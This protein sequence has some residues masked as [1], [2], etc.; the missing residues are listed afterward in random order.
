MIGRVQ[1]WSRVAVHNRTSSHDN[2][3]WYTNSYHD[4]PPRRLRRGAAAPRGRTMTIHRVLLH[5]LVA[6]MLYGCAAATPVPTF[7]ARHPLPPRGE[8][9]LLAIVPLISRVPSGQV[10]GAI[11]AGPFCET[12]SKATWPVADGATIGDLQ[13]MDALDATLS[14]SGYK[15]VKRQ[16]GP[17]DEPEE[18]KAEL[19]I[20]GSLKRVNFN[21]C[22]K[23]D[24]S[25]GEAAVEIEWQIFDRQ[26]RSVLLAL[27]T[28]GSAKLPPQP[29]GAG[30]VYVSAINAAL[31]NLLAEERFVTTVS[32]PTQQATQE[33]TP[34]TVTVVSLDADLAASS[35]LIEY[36]RDGVV[37]IPVGSGHGS[38][39]VVSPTGLVIT[40]AH[41]IRDDQAA[42]VAELP[43]D[44]K[45]K[46]WLVRRNAEFDV[47]L[48]QLEPGEYRAIPVGSA[49]SLH[50]GD[51]VFA[52]GAPLDQRLTRT[53]TKGV[54]SA[55]REDPPRKWIQSDVTVHPG[56]SGG[57]LLDDRGRVVGVAQSGVTLQGRVGIGLNAFV[58]IADVWK[59]LGITLRVSQLDPAQLGLATSPPAKSDPATE[60]GQKLK[61]VD[62]LARK[63]L[64]TSEEAERRRK[65]ILDRAIR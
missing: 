42:V 53:V 23:E 48:I 54:V 38:G 24:E 16:R 4:R 55:L 61:L 44:R 28:G 50:V 56:S 11:Q 15:L 45:A 3:Q 46:G 26:T 51:T 35:Q 64:I 52:V 8:S 34:L 29:G 59:A 21:L 18:W 22:R 9:R 5:G 41:V 14:I 47:A 32:Q 36:A 62:E 43:G 17:F 60:I 12:V 49:A 10:V 2:V 63:G 57:P 33:Q 31:A 39:F 58:P 7:E 27:T 30:T 25:S 13:M 19:L 37:T 65:E 20:G 1:D 6:S 40:A